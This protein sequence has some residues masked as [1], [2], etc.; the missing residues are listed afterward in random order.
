MDPRQTKRS[1]R[2][3]EESMSLSGGKN[4]AMEDSEEPS[5]SEM[6]A[7]LREEGLRDSGANDDDF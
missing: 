6:D 3:G 7:T 5:E 2:F 1:V 4:N